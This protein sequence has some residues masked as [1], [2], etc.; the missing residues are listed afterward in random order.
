LLLLG[1]G[2]IAQN[3]WSP[4]EDSHANYV[5]ELYCGLLALPLCSKI[6]MEPI[7]KSA[8]G[9]NP[10]VITNFRGERWAIACKVMHSSLTKSLL[11]R[12]REGIKQ[13]NRCDK[14]EN[15][16][17]AVSLKNVVAHDEIW[18][19][20]QETGTGDFIYGT[21]S[22]DAM[23]L[24]VMRSTMKR[25]E[26]ELVEMLG[27]KEGF[28]ALFKDSKVEPLIFVYICTVITVLEGTHSTFKLLKLAGT[29]AVDN[30]LPAKTRGF[31]EAMNESLHDTYLNPA[32]PFWKEFKPN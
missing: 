19:A 1:D 18:P 6:E 32:H 5:F 23:A 15:G 4:K 12:V 8:N 10:D 13:I 29:I 30:P 11:D 27:G 9:A 2:E 17:I 31:A 7:Q 25:Y 21:A 24:D 16:L 26:C 14:A 20:Y 3:L 22:S 28:R